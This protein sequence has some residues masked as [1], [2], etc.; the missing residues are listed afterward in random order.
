MKVALR[1]YAVI[2]RIESNFIK[3]NNNTVTGQYTKI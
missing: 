1:S 3:F 2:M